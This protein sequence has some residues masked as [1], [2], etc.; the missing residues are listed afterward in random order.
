MMLLP[1]GRLVPMRC[2]CSNLC[3][4]C[5]W[6]AAVENSLVVG[7]DARWSQPTVGMTLTT[8]RPDFDLDRFRL[9]VA[10]VFKWM[11]RDL[12]IDCEY[13]GLMEWTTGSGGK[14]R[15]PHMH[16]LLKGADADDLGDLVADPR[17][18]KGAPPRYEFELR[19]REKWEAWTG[20]AWIVDARPLRSPGGAIAYTVGHHHKREQAPPRRIARFSSDGT[21]RYEQT[22]SVKRMRPSRGYFDTRRAEVWNE[23]NPNDPKRPVQMFREEAR[24][25][26][27]RATAEKVALAQLIDSDVPEEL[28]NEVLDDLIEQSLRGPRPVPVALMD[29]GRMRHLSTGQVFETIEA[30]LEAE[31]D[32][33]DRR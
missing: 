21:I 29:D 15:M 2:G 12:G 16:T 24:E 11:R 7:L 30:A 18:K 13:L 3:A 9:A 31:A 28:H 22:K 33:T 17:A 6:L 27:R 19:L 23:H 20:G 4:Y 32:A 26:M 1:D 10:Q 25:V 5:A 14:G 8:H